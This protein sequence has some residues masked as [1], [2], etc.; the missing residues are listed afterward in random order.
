MDALTGSEIIQFAM[1]GI[2]SVG[3]AVVGWFVSKIF[4]EIKKSR[5]NERELYKEAGK[6]REDLLKLHIKMLEDTIHTLR[7]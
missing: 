3:M 4:E 7:K 1:S 2:L 6:N 5:D